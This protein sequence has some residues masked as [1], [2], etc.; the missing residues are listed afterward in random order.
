MCRVS[1]RTRALTGADY[2]TEK[3]RRGDG[4]REGRRP[5]Y[6]IIMK[7]FVRLSQIS[8]SFSPVPIRSPAF[9]AGLLPS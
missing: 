5:N 7:R 9:P 1:S 3:S 2:A 4:R 6:E 8:P